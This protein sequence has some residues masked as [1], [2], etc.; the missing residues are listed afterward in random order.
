MRKLETESDAFAF[1]DKLVEKWYGT[2]E[3][4]TNKGVL[5]VVTTSKVTGA[6]HSQQ[7]PPWTAA[8]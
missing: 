1:G 5:I 4:G 3:R 8:P 6:C 7:R 2:V